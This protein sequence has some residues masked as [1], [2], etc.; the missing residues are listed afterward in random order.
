MQ[1]ANKKFLQCCALVCLALVTIS[2]AAAKQ[3]ILKPDEAF[4][5]TV[6][7]T[8]GEMS[9]QWTIEP[10][11]YLYKER[12]S[13]ASRT[14]AVTIGEARMPAGEAHEDEFFG[15]MHIYRNAAEIRIPIATR[16]AG[17]DTLELELR[18]QGCAD[19]GLCYPPQVWTTRVDLPAPDATAGGTLA[20]M[21]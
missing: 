3:D 17:A 9:V 14:A 4:R 2:P 7:A 11:H 15:E 21:M 6:T 13:Y 8:P 18:S 1:P 19:I 16:A 10:G 12:M 20:R 5:Y